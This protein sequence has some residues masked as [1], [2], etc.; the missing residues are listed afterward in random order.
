MVGIKHS[1]GI[2][3]NESKH[4]RELPPGLFSMVLLWSRSL[5]PL[6]GP[7]PTLPTSRV[8]LRTSGFL[9]VGLPGSL[10]FSVSNF[11]S[12]AFLFWGSVLLCIIKEDRVGHILK[13]RL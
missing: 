11:F 3:Q 5:R 8:T 2:D 4:N 7:I 1:K 6:S 10:S 13:G 12:P 9:R